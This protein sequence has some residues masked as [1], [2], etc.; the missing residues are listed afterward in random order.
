MAQQRA[1]EII[2]RLIFISV[3]S[4][5]ICVAGIASAQQTATSQPPV[6][7]SPVTYDS[8]GLRSLSVAMGD[9]NGDGKLD[10]VVT[11]QCINDDDCPPDEY[12]VGHGPVGVLLGNGDGTFQPV[13]TYP[14]G[15]HLLTI[16]SFSVAVGD[17]NGDGKLDIAIVN[18]ADS[19]NTPP[20][21]SQGSVELLF[22]NGDGTF[23]SPW[24]YNSYG[25]APVS[26]ALADLNEDG[27]LDV[28]MANICDA[29][30]TC[31][32]SGCEC[33]TGSVSVLL[34]EDFGRYSIRRYGAPPWLRS[35]TV[36]D[37]NGDSKPDAVVNG[38]VLLGNGDG[39]FQP[40][41]AYSADIGGD[42]SSVVLGDVNGDGKLD[43]I[44]SV[45]T[46]SRTST[47]GA[48]AVL[49]GNGNGTFQPAVSYGSGASYA[50]SLAVGDVNGDGKPDAVVANDGGVGIL[51]GNGDG[52]FQ[53]AMVFR[54][55]GYLPMSVALGDLNGDDKLDIALADIWGPNGGAV[56]VLLN[57][58]QFC[59]TP[60][61]V[62]LSAT[63]TT[64]WPPNGN[65]VPVTISGMITDPDTGCPIRTAVYAVEDEYAK[66]QLGGVVTSA[67]GGAYSFTV[68]LQASRRGTDLDGR[69]YKV[70]VTAS[71]DAGR[72][73]SKVVN[74][75]VPH[76]QRR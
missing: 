21:C 52:T 60:P 47:N 53:P 12:S 33:E 19:C 16:E 76:D 40:S 31:G 70:T 5:S 69:S 46:S 75:I 51:L 4:L 62:T 36:G 58:T 34:S 28:L 64:V 57:N 26:V 44:L 20:G 6:F 54:N 56:S 66:V 68:Q 10:L 37:V 27:M 22:G 50:R 49:L 17:L 61:V 43:L 14:S 9:L 32:I 7:L 35:I 8:G 41:L 24:I 74:V 18:S 2:L 71:N 23:G 15:N 72:T 13:V 73:G 55:G 45:V 30:P 3:A 42:L 11:N 48:V 63:P 65:M 25:F 67:P 29:Y 38:G 1:L 59:T 39:A